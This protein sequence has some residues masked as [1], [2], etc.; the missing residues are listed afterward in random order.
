MTPR[1]VLT[2]YDTRFQAKYG[3]RAP[4][5]K[6][7]DPAIAKWLLENYEFP[8]LE[9]LFDAFFAIRDPFIESAG[10]GLGVLRAC[11]PKVIAEWR[12]R[13]ARQ[14]KQQAS[15]SVV[16]CADCSNTGWVGEPAVRCPCRTVKA[17]S[18]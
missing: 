10:H 15:L 3:I 9:E 6:G 11:L 8:Q 4:I 2:A 16:W 17:R 1:D 12:R 18:A 5:Q 7:K 14:Q 13:K